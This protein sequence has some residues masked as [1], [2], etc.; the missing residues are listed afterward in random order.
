MNFEY[1][2]KRSGYVREKGFQESSDTSVHKLV[3]VRKHDM[4]YDW[5]MQQLLLKITAGNRGRKPYLESLQ[6]RQG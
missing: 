2:D 5:H 3:E 6:L 1:L 4:Y